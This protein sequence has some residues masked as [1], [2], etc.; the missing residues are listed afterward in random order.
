MCSYCGCEAEAVIA[1]LMAD[2]TRISDL[3]YRIGRALDDQRVDEAAGL[4]QELAR[5][6]AR[7]THLE[8]TGL[9]AELIRRGGAGEE[10]DRLVGEHRRL[11]PAL[12][13]EGL[14]DD[15]GQLRQL[16]GEVARHA[17]VEDSDLFPFAVQMLPDA[18]WAELGS[19]STAVAS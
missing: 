4:I 10:I 14:V 9:F 16:L 17:E 3:G 18:C 7:H 8:E 12:A 6:F 5:I 1:E 2:H 19:E 11:R 13:A 15:V